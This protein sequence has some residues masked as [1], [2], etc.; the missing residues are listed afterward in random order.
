M[1]LQSAQ[2]AQFAWVTHQ[3]PVTKWLKTEVASRAPHLHFA[4][5]RPGLTTFKITGTANDTIV[6]P[7]SFARA[8]GLS[9]GRA[10][11]VAEVLAL[12]TPLARNAGAP[13]RLHVFERDI[14]VPVDEQDPTVRGTRARAIEADLRAIA[15]SEGILFEVEAKANVGDRVIDVIVP[16]ASEPN[17]AWLVGTHRHSAMHGPWPGGV[18]HVALPEEAPSRAWCKIEE[19]LR[20]ADLTPSPGQ[21]AVEIGSSP[22]GATYAL[23]CRGLN[24]YGVDPGEMHA[25]CVNFRGPHHNRFVHLHMPAAEVPKS[26]L[27]P[28][29][30]WLLSDVNLAP[31]VAMRYIE[32]FVALAHGGL[33]G[34]VLTLKLNDDGVFAAL[35]RILARIDKLGP[36]T[37]RVTQLPSHRSEV[38]A[39]LTF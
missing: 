38:V 18:Q 9:V 5:S 37:V 35:P 21:D 1:T 15:P 26:Q 20:W 19:A 16:H 8:W 17:E 39:I 33:K 28:K 22:G 36:K 2:F 23:L 6:V 10:T 11:K 24:V 32:R 25:R 12:I 31:M 14:D 13:L 4:F 34:A 7:S 27:P 3:V 29:Y 30:Q